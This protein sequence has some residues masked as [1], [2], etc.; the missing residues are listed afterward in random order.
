MTAPR[1][2]LA[3]ITLLAV[4]PASASAATVTVT[5]DDGNPLAINTAAPTPIRNTGPEYVVTFGASD[6][7]NHQTSVIG[8]DGADASFG[9]PTRC[10]PKSAIP[11]QRRPIAYRG[12]GNYAVI[13]QTFSDDDCTAGRKESRFLFS[14]NGGTVVVAPAKKYLLTR[15]KNSFRSITHRFGLGVNP[16]TSAYEFQYLKNGVIGPDGGFTGPASVTGA[17]SSAP[18]LDLTFQEPGRYTAVA[19]GVHEPVLH[20]VQPA[21]QLHGQGAL[22]PL[23]RDVPG[24]AGPELQAARPDA[25]QVRPRQP[26]DGL[27]REGPQGRQVPQA[28][29]HLQG[30]LARA[31]HAPLPPRAATASTACSTATRAPSS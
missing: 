19:R 21:R 25:R 22:R 2:V 1:A 20:A 15:Q 30:Q 31:L 28:R 17:S 26:R 24:L 13:V 18:F 16:G 3:T 10:Y 23:L 14:I 6:G 11:S 5:G 7:A 27:R 8:P 29:P 4:L 9:G 12:N